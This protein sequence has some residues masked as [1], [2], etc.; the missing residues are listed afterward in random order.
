MPSKTNARWP[1]VAA[2]SPGRPSQDPVDQKSV[3]VRFPPPAVA[4]SEPREQ[5]QRLVVAAHA[6]ELAQKQVP[7]ALVVVG[8][9]SERF[10]EVRGCLVRAAQ[11]PERLR[12]S[13]PRQAD[14]S[15][16]PGVRTSPR[17]ALE[18][19]QQ[20]GNRAIGSTVD[21]GQHQAASSATA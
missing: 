2:S 5:S 17:Q 19:P 1:P 9:E 16:L 6:H 21:P 8:V 4:L 12:E 11:L 18:T 13:Q 10:V 15:S 14:N 20:D 7:H 3:W